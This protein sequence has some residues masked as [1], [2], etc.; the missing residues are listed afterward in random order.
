MT[1]KAFGRRLRRLRASTGLSLKQVAPRL[2]IDYTYLSKLETGD[3][4]PSEELVRRMARYY[5]EDPGSLLVA[6]GRIPAE[7][8]AILQRH[9]ED[10]LAFLRERFGSSKQQP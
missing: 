7:I 1:A 9:P 4:R 2:R 8:L 5:E 3:V 10:A 6:A